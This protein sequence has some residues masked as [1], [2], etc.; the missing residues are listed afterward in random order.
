MS[1]KFIVKKHIPIPRKSMNVFK[2]FWC[3]RSWYS[4]KTSEKKINRYAKLNAIS[5]LGRYKLDFDEVKFK[6]NCL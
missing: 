1:N 2:F 5:E 6:W 3:V 4:S